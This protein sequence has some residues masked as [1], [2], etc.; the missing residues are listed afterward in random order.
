MADARAAETER[1][2]CD[3]PAPTAARGR[4]PSNR[5]SGRREGAFRPLSSSSAPERDSRLMARGD[6]RH[7]RRAALANDVLVDIDRPAQRLCYVN[8]LASS[9]A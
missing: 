1:K 3:L 8:R 4:T 7:L 2:E 9:K 5:K 6:T